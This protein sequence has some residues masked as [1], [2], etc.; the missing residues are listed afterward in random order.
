MAVRESAAL[1]L[2][3]IVH[4]GQNPVTLVGAVLTTSSAFTL[5]AFWAIEILRGGPVPAYTG[6]I[7][8]L[9]LRAVFFV[10]LILMP[11]GALRRRARLRAAGQLPQIYP[12]IDFRSPYLRRVLVL[13]A[14]ATFINAAILSMATYRGVTYMDSVQFCGETC[15]A[16]MAP[17]HTAY[18]DSP[19]SRVACVSCHIGHQDFPGCF[20]CHDGSHA[21]ADGRVITQDCNACHNI[22]AMEEPSPKIL[23]D[24]G[25]R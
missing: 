16:V 19:H 3:P 11:L 25:L 6:I 12:Q 20:R 9:I 22:L 18:Q 4:I 21:S 1:W 7:F 24:L 8:F 17:E 2:R 5:I 10:G 14:A 15:H 23:S 13:V